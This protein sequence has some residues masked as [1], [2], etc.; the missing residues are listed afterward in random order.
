MA[1]RPD[2]ADYRALFMGDVPMMDMRAPSE[3]EHGAFP[4]AASLPLMSD[5]E[6]AQVGTCYKQEGQE[7]AIALGHQLV[8]GELKTERLRAW[9]DFARWS[10]PIPPIGHR[11]YPNCSG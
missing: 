10:G 11:S 1:G 5:G 9:S 2:S 3:F 8:A 6:R 4:C 7:A